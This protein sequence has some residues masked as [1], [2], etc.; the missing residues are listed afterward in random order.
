VFDGGFV[1]GERALALG[2]IDRFGDVDGVVREVGGERARAQVFRP[3]RRGLLSRL[4][5]LAVEAVF[6]ALEARSGPKL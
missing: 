5:R 6:D 4:P 1:L 3:R 2:L